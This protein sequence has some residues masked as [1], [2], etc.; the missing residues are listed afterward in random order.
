MSNPDEIR[1]NLRFTD[2][3]DGVPLDD[4]RI[5]SFINQVLDKLRNGETH[6]SIS[7]GNCTVIGMVFDHEY[8]ITVSES[9]RRATIYKRDGEPDIDHAVAYR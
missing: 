4:Y 1:G 8:Q 9:Y 7:S 6:A 2:M 3:R 5:N